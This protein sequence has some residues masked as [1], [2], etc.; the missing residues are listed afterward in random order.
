MRIVEDGCEGV[1]VAAAEKLAAQ[2]DQEALT[3]FLSHRMRW[4]SRVAVKHVASQRR[5]ALVA[6]WKDRELANEA[7]SR[8]SDQKYIEY[9]MN[10]PSIGYMRVLA[11]RK[12]TEPQR[13]DRLART[14]SD[15]YQVVEALVPHMADREMLIGLATQ[16]IRLGAAEA[17]LAQLDQANPTGR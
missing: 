12:I 9:V 5:L 4:G 10:R 2:N 14:Y 16:D 15:D 17:R 7:L 6:C 13:A 11:A 1:G 3:T 8:L